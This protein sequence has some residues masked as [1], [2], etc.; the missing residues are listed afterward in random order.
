MKFRI[1]RIRDDFLEKVRRA[2]VDD[3]DQPVERLAAVGGEPCRDV[4]R[5][6]R[7]GENVIL[8]SYCPFSRPGPY[9]EYGPV[10]VLAEPAAERVDWDT[11]PLPTGDGTAYL[12]EPFVLRA[13]DAKERIVAATLSRAQSCHADLKAL[14][15]GYDTDFVLARFAAYGCYG[16]RIHVDPA[17]AGSS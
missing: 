11:V 13:Y 16:F 15:T 12:G 7:P 2:G 14:F 4:L 1:A 3:L 9:K 8:A 17:S 5:R 10:F 6:A